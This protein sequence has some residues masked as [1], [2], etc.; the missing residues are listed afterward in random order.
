MRKTKVLCFGLILLL[1]SGALAFASGSSGDSG[2]QGAGTMEFKDVPEQEMKLANW[3]ADLKLPIADELTEISIMLAVGLEYTEPDAR[4]YRN[5]RDLEEITNIRSVWRLFDRNDDGVTMTAAVASGET[6]PDL[7]P[8]SAQQMRAFYEGGLTVA[9]EDYILQNAPDLKHLLEIRPNE[10]KQMWHPDGHMPGVFNFNRQKVSPP[11][12]YLRK[13]WMDKL[14]IPMPT[15]LEMFEDY[16]TAITTQDPNGN[17]ELDEFGDYVWIID[18]LPGRFAFLFDLNPINGNLILEDDNK[19]LAFR[20]FEP[21]AKD[22]VEWMK[23]AY[24]NNWFE[25]VVV[26]MERIAYWKERGMHQTKDHGL[27]RYSAG[28]AKRLFDDGWPVMLGEWVEM[29]PWEGSINQGW[30]PGG[31][32]GGGWALTATAE[33]PD[34]AIAWLSYI[35]ANRDGYL[36]AHKGYEGI[37]WEMPGADGYY[38]IYEAADFKDLGYDSEEAFNNRHADDPLWGF[39][40]QPWFLP[41]EDTRVQDDPDPISVAMTEKFMHT[42]RDA[43]WPFV[44]PLENETAAVDN[45]I[46]NEGDSY[47]LW[48][49]IKFISG[50][51]SMD[52]WD[53]F[54]EQLEK[55]GAR[56]Y[57]KS[58]QSMYDRFYSAN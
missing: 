28:T 3:S 42:I 56:E 22:W 24:N 17:G 18:A 7:I 1:V 52:T 41:Y 19:T 54:L 44:M 25:K 51:R 33:N 43:F 37:D 21:R 50:E 35:L 29:L 49:T 27:A 10:R 8:V 23:K 36:L 5:W 57:T 45:W 40:E 32:H 47:A 46:E 4:D 55:L 30:S 26:D 2:S 38:K 14:N 53:Q 15:N 9:V 39:H 48:E 6:L 13:D 12:Y 31:L 20:Y 58:M 16:L 34:L 11:V